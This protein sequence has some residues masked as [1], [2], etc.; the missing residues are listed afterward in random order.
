M[1]LRRKG[2]PAPPGL[3]AQCG[4]QRG[5]HFEDHRRGS[6]GCPG[7]A[8]PPAGGV[9]FPVVY[10]RRDPG[11][12]SAPVHRVASRSAHIAVGAGHGRYQ[13]RLG[14]LGPGPEEGASLKGGSCAF[15]LAQP[16]RR[17]VSDRRGGTSR[18]G[19]KRAGE[20]DGLTGL[21]E[22]N[23]G[24]PGPRPRSRPARVPPGSAPLDAVRLLRGPPEG[25][26]RSQGRSAPP[27]TRRPPGRL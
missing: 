23:A 15:V 2:Y 8:A 11:R 3:H 6:R 18:T 13:A 24:S 25:R 26:G 5:D 19:A 14:Y 12:W 21:P 1:E 22:A 9:L 10:H 4:A 27:R 16:Q 20:C 7:V 17:G